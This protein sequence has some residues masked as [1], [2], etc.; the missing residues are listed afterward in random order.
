MHGCKKAELHRL[1]WHCGVRSGSMAT[2]RARNSSLLRHVRS[3]I[4]FGKPHGRAALVRLLAFTSKT[5]GRFKNNKK[6]RE[7]EVHMTAWSRR[8]SA[9]VFDKDGPAWET[10]KRRV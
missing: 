3:D 9:Q 7:R 6:Y 2:G 4:L 1:Q 5:T 8:L 10:P